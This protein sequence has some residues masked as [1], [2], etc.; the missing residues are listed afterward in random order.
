V[1]GGRGESHGQRKQLRCGAP[2]RSRLLFM[3]YMIK[4]SL[5]EGGPP[6][7]CSSRAT[8]CVLHRLWSRFLCF[9]VWGIFAS[10]P[11][12]CPPPPPPPPPAARPPPQN[13]TP[14]QH[15]N[16]I[17]N[18]AVGGGGGGGGGDR[19]EYI[20]VHMLCRLTVIRGGGDTCVQSSQMIHDKYVIIEHVE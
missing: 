16:G 20:T 6:Y 2:A 19:D 7:D 3:P 13:N 18:P 11:P 5:W 14:P 10:G 4:H 9:G 17:T 15:I 8:F 1:G 12:H